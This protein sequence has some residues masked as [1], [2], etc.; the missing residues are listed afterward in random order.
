[1]KKKLLSLALALTLG[2]G[3]LT[4]PAAAA[5]TAVVKTFGEEV[6]P[7]FNYRVYSDGMLAAEKDYP[8]DSAASG[9][10][11]LDRDGNEIPGALFADAMN[12]SEGMAAAAPKL[13]KSSDYKGYGYIDKTGKM[14]IT[15]RFETAGQF[16]GGLARVKDQE[17]GKWGMIDTSGNVVIP[18]EYGSNNNGPYV[19]EVSDGLIAAYNSADGYWGYFDTI[20][21]TAIPFQYANANDFKNGYAKVRLGQRE[22]YID[23]FGRDIIPQ[24]YEYIEQLTVDGEPAALFSARDTTATGRNTYYL[25]NG[26]G[27][28]V[29]GPYDSFGRGGFDK[30]FFNGLMA[31]TRNDGSN[32]LTGYINTAGQEVIPFQ[33]RDAKAFKDGYAFVRTQDNTEAIINTA[34]QITAILSENI[35]YRTSTDNPSGLLGWGEGFLAVSSDE[36][37]RTR[38]G[39]INTA[40]QL[41]VDYKYQSVEAFSSGVAVVRNFDNQ[42]GLINTAGQ[43]IAPCKY[44]SIGKFI[45]GVAVVS[46]VHHKGSLGNVYGYGLINTAG[47]EIL[48]CKYDEGI[49]SINSGSVGALQ[50]SLQKGGQEVCAILRNL[51]TDLYDFIRITTDYAAAPAQP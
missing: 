11:F 21:Q 4:V 41:V 50:D 38:S 51:D 9:Y 16:H 28:V 47:Q 37:G 17:T 36:S 2:L 27:Q 25:L 31:A 14:V 20:G 8:F 6:E 1:M 22:T 45:N 34:G 5:S 46:V 48:P 39:F 43:E 40:G 13:T 42:C 18:F 26:N 23:K 35:K 29:A 19:H 10:I 30:G 7:A 49:S 24:Q 33:F 12:F 3:V 32:S 44:T 15:P